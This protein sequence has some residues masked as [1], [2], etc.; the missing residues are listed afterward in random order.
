MRFEEKG[1][2]KTARQHAERLKVRAAGELQPR[3]LLHPISF[4]LVYPVTERSTL[5]CTD[6]S[7]NSGAED[8][9]EKKKT[10]TAYYCVFHIVK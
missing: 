8:E 6:L 2:I 10:T 5:A 7:S 1:S 4:Y 3:F 9:R